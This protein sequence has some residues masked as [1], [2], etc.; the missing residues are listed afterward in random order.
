METITRYRK[1]RRRKMSN[2]KY[3]EEKER[4]DEERKNNENG[5]KEKWEVKR[6]NNEYEISRIITINRIIGMRKKRLKLRRR[7]I[8][9]ITR[10]IGGRKRNR[11]CGRKIIKIREMKE[12]VQRRK[13]KNEEKDTKKDGKRRASE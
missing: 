13:E 10:K 6:K 3:E 12:R 7:G 11:R 9:Q 2:V 4:N 1:G 8:E 5:K